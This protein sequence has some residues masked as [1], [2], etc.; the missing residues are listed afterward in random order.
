M[1]GGLLNAGAMALFALV[2]AYSA[3]SSR[4]A[5]ARDTAG[6]LRTSATIGTPEPRRDPVSTFEGAAECLL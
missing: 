5:D 2:A 4:R 3:F 1:I 6:T